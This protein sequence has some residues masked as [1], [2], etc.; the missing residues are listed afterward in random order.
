MTGFVIGLMVGIF[1]GCWTVYFAH[2]WIW[3]S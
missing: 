3:R 2:D 1:V